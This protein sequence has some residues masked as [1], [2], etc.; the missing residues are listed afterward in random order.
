MP[1]NNAMRNCY[2]NGITH[3]NT[4]PVN[5]SMRNCYSRTYSATSLHFHILG[6]VFC[7]LQW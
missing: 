3:S 7:Y 6:S 2:T 4:M 1:V 5:N